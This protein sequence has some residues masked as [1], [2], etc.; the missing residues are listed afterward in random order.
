M[1]EAT[2]PQD[3]YHAHQLVRAGYV[4]V[5]VPLGSA[6]RATLG[7]RAERGSQE[8][9]SFDLFDHSRITDR[10]GYAR[11]DWLPSA[12]L[13][14]AARRDINVR[15]AASRTL[16]RPDLNELSTSPAFEYIGGFQQMGNPDLGRTLIENYDVRLEAFPALSEVLA[17]GL[18]YKRLHRPDRAGARAVDADGSEAV[19]LGS[20]PESRRRARGAR[21]FGR[22]TPALS[23]FSLN[24]NASFMSTR[25]RLK[26]QLTVYGSEE[27][28]LQGQAAYVLNGA[29]GYASASGRVDAALLLS[30]VG[31]RLD[32]LGLKAIGDIY[33]RPSASLDAT[34]GFA[35]FPGSRVK[36]SA[37]N[38]LDPRIQRVQG[39]REVAGYRSGRTYSLALSFG[40]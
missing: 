30:A 23:R 35:P 15:L 1:D 18:F 8:V 16:S 32:S 34:M 39:G 22:L 17:A 11:T 27:H 6:L 24:A 38:L 3:N 12:N 13:T 4:S 25:V 7:V 28:P 26:P 36:L 5:D 40:S 10:G 19:Q 31:H 2:L 37:R 29:L 14:W 9:R 20:R 21:G 33:E